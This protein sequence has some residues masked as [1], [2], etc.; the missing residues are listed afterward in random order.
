MK[1][2]PD[3]L[4]HPHRPHYTSLCQ[5]NNMQ[6]AAL[7]LQRGALVPDDNPRGLILCLFINMHRRRL[8]MHVHAL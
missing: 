6:T 4:P 2:S 7:R 8:S 3:C 1:S 5:V